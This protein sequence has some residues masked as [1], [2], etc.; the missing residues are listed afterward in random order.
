VFNAGSTATIT[1]ALNITSG[2]CGGFTNINS[3]NPGTQATISMPSGS[4]TADYVNL[5]DIRAIGGATFNATNA[6]NLGNNTGWNITNL[7]SRELYWI[8]GSGNWGDGNKWSLTSGGSALGCAPTSLDNVHFDA[9][10]FSSTGATVTINVSTPMCNDMDWTGVS[11]APT[12]NG[13]GNTLKIYGSLT[14]VTGMTV[15]TNTHVSFEATTIGKTI[16]TA[17]RVFGNLTLNG[18]G[19][20]WT[21]QDAINSAS[22]SI[23]LSN[24]SF[25]T[26]NKTLTIANFNSDNGN[27]RTMTLGTTVMNL[28]G[29]WNTRT[30][31]GFTLNAGTSSI[32]LTDGR[33]YQGEGN[34]SNG[35]ALTYYD[36]NFAPTGTRKAQLY[37][38][39]G[40]GKATYHNLTST[41]GLEKAGGGAK[42]IVTNDFTCP[43]IYTAYWG[44]PL[45]VSGTATFGANA[46]FDDNTTFNNVIFYP[47]N[48]IV[49]TAG[50]TQTITGILN[51][52]GT[53]IAPITIQSSS[54]S[55][56][57]TISKSS[58]SV[59]LDYVILDHITAAG[60]ATFD[61]GANSTNF[62][63]SSIGFSYAGTCTLPAGPPS[64]T[65]VNVPSNGS[66]AAGQNLDFTVNYS[67][68]VTVTGSPFIPIT[69]NTGGA[70]NATYLSG[71][72]TSSITFR[73]IVAAGNVDPDGILVGSAITINGG[74]IKGV[75]SFN[76]VLTLNNIGLTTAVLVDAIAPT[77][78]SINRVG[79]TPNKAISDQFTVTFS[80]NVT[81]VDATDFT[82]VASGTLTTAGITVSAVSGAIYTVTVA[83]VNGN[84]TLG[85][86][87]NNSGTAIADIAGNAIS[88]GFTGQLYT[89]D[90]ITQ[91]PI[92]NLPTAAGS[93]DGVSLSVSLN[94][95]EAALSNSITLTFQGLSNTAVATLNN[96]TGNIIGNLVTNNLATSSIVASSSV[97]ALQPDLYTI[98]LSYQDA[99]GNPT[100][101]A[102]ITNF[103]FNMSPTWTGTTS[104]N[105]ATT[106]NWNTLSIPMSSSNVTIPNVANQPIISST[107][108][109]VVKNLSINSG[110][111]LKIAGILTPSGTITNTG[112]LIVAPGGALVGSA[113]NVSG[114]VTVQQNIV[115]Q[116][117][118]RVFGNPFTTTQTLS[119]IA[120]TNG[121]TV[122]TSAAITD[123]RIY[124]N[125]NDTWANNNLDIAA[126]SI[127]ALFIRGLASEVTGI[128]YTGD[129]TPF[130]FSL[131]GTLN[132]SSVSRTQ[133]SAFPFRAISNPYAAPVT[134]QALTGGVSKPYY[135]YQIPVTSSPRVKSGSWVAAGANSSVNTAIPVLGVL[136]YTPS[137]STN[138]N[139]TTADIN[140]NG[141]TQTGLFSVGSTLQQLELVLENNG[142]YADKIFIRQDATAT[143]NGT[144]NNDLQ[145]YKNE[146]SNLYTTTPDGMHMAIDARSDFGAVIPL[147]VSSV[148]GNYK[149]KVN[150]N[151][152]SIGSDVYLK[153]KLL[154]VL[155]EL[156]TGAKY[157]FAISSDTAT[158]GEKRFEIFFIK[159]LSTLTAF[160][161]P[162]NTGLQMKVLGNVVNGNVLYVQVNGLKAEEVGSLSIV[163]LSGRVITVK[164]VTNGLNRISINNA[165]NGVHLVQL[166]NS[167]NLVTQKFIKQ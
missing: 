59:C 35:F 57:S 12:F 23:N 2:N 50:K 122:G 89:V 146:V 113:S 17:G 108:N 115:G 107:T 37:V 138:F 163:D 111:S 127:F 45:T 165:S 112:T 147:G 110:A 128:N 140:T 56:Q 86:N 3:S 137:S 28:G 98:V 30:T 66:Y 43:G 13:G 149:F 32:N 52:K 120:S 141:M 154:N 72:G 75:S 22:T 4:V 46:T 93:Y 158:Q 124:T 26:N 156:K 152:L 109:A 41:K 92:I 162:S 103:S 82:I 34:E 40:G 148:E 106:T 69:L 91:N 78:N 94:I 1:T 85:L 74:S 125:T 64:V 36:V 11:N 58:G 63:S 25:N 135:T 9:N 62:A 39:N 61:A 80:E 95:P 116:R 143:V 60:G 48:T 133:N 33:F 157:E 134:T 97:S 129:P 70:V 123:T 160:D 51:A 142:D 102:S 8:G 31:N 83:G 99:L 38:Y 130:V 19:G 79:A 136:A 155:T 10:S 118:W 104:T 153:D 16:T 164:T 144:D 150:G 65:N 73:Y 14:F 159:P 7:A 87:L 88:G 42:V 47:G 67:E 100:S 139:I 53:S 76:A 167:K 131:S 84:G 119:N 49:F 81:G 96:A 126:N 101:T 151:H 105:W 161:T 5:K 132:A 24:G 15:T 71:S 6:I 166:S 20:G 145:K 27:T 68:N 55:A 117:G 77:I 90:Q 114:S 18:I 21:L 29:D 121:I 44:G 54:A